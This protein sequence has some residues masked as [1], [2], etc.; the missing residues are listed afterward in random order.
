MDDDLKIALDELRRMNML[1]AKRA[2][3]NARKQK[4]PFEESG[5]TNPRIRLSQA[6]RAARRRASNRRYYLENLEAQRARGR[7]KYHARKVT[8]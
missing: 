4:K 2:G 6:E 8:R 5:V 1:T 3:Q 7:L